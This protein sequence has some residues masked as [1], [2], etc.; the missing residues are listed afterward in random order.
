MPDRDLR[1]AP[2]TGARP[3][4]Q[5]IDASA[6]GAAV[7]QRRP[8]RAHAPTARGPDLT[9]R[10]AVSRGACPPTRTAALVLGARVPTPIATVV[11]SA[12]LPTPSVS[13]VLGSTLPTHA[14]T[15]VGS[16]RLNR[17][18]A[19]AQ[20]LHA[21][22]WPE[23]SAVVRRPQAAV[24]AWNCTL[25]VALFF[26]NDKTTRADTREWRRRIKRACDSG[27]RGS[28]PHRTPRRDGALP[29]DGSRGRS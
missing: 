29:L 25:D 17:C 21:P 19:R 28:Y 11:P 18:A 22:P 9:R 8:L 14:A 20:E 3:F 27:P 7:V 2:E 16:D 10:S 1:I 5:C 4:T 13:V 15:V 6:R 12:H 26:R 23:K 24:G